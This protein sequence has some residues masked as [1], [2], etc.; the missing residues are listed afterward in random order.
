MTCILILVS[1]RFWRETEIWHTSKH[2]NV[3]PLLGIVNKYGNIYMVSRWAKHGNLLEY[4]TRNPLVDRLSLVSRMLSNSS[5]IYLNTHNAMK[6]LGIAA[7]MT[8][9]HNRQPAVIHGDLKSV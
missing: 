6:L 3:L 9:L 7:G 5:R 2:T 4:I 8:Y 1:K